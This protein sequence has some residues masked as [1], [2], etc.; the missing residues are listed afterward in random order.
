VIGHQGTNVDACPNTMRAFRRAAR[1]ADVIETDIQ[2]TADGVLVVYHDKTLDSSTSGSGPVAEQTYRQLRRCRMADGS[3]IPSFGQLLRWLRRTRLTLVA[4]LKLDGWS[5]QQAATYSRM[6]RRWGMLD[7]TIASSFDPRNLAHLRSVD[8]EITRAMVYSRAV[9]SIDQIRAAGAISM[10]WFK[11][12]SADDVSA[13]QAAGL[14]VWCWTAR[15]SSQYRRALDLGVDGIVADDPE[16]L[17]RWLA[18]E[19]DVITRPAVSV[20]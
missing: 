4:E 19:G 18:A 6:I 7:R 12:T 1:C 17:R 20:G 14:R 5:V 15:S 2:V 3:H 16:A 8:P 10:P 11:N 13:L 9:P